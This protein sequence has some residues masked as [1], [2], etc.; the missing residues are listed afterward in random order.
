VAGF[1]APHIDQLRASEDPLEACRDLEFF[2]RV[3]LKALS[4]F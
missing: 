2:G 1:I 3:H 4:L